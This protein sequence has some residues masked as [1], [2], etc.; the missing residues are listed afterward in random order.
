M[1]DASWSTE[2]PVLC[3]A[4][5]SVSRNAL[6]SSA[7]RPKAV[8]ADCTL[9]IED[10]TDVPFICA[11]FIK[12][13]ESFSSCSPVTSNLVFTSATASAASSKDVGMEVAR[14]SQI[15]CSSRTASPVAPVFL[16][17]VSYAA[18]TSF[19]AF[20]EAA[21]PA[22]IGAVTYLLIAVPAF[23]ILSPT[24]VT[25]SPSSFIAAEPDFRAALTSLRE[26]SY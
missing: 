12:S 2:T 18:S 26:A 21:A 4:A 20:T 23:C 11:N 8:I 15:P 7:D 24:F 13:P 17:M 3:D 14:S 5:V 22:T 19:H 9:S 10:D 16:M 25:A 1:S 6:V